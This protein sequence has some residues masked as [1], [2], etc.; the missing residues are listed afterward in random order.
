MPRIPDEAAPVPQVPGESGGDSTV[1]RP[2]HLTIPSS[3]TSC[4]QGFDYLF[5]LFDRNAHDDRGTCQ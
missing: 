4:H 5:D 3:D 1:L 2:A